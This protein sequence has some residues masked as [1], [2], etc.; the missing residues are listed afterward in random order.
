MA[1]KTV[2]Q[3]EIYHSIGLST[4]TKPAG[5]TPLSTFFAYDTFV[6]YVTYDGTNWVED[7]RYTKS[8]HN[9]T[10]IGHGVKTVSTNGTDEALAASTACKQVI[11]QAQTDNTSAVA[12]GAAGVD[13]TVATGNGLL[14][15]A[16]DW[17]PPINIDNL[18]DIYVDALVAG[19]G[20]RYI[21]FT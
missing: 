4:D 2:Y 14:L 15:Y 18:A 7:T 13:A 17:T 1:V 5:Q 8:G 12:I 19:E 3:H 21:Y 11:I 6:P 9:I 20:V 10:S 16:G